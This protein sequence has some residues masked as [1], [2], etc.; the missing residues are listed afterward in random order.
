MRLCSCGAPRL[1]TESFLM[2]W[3]TNNI[4]LKL[5]LE[6]K[7]RHKSKIQENETQ[8]TRMYLHDTLNPHLAFLHIP[9]VKLNSIPSGHYGEFHMYAYT[10]SNLN[11]QNYYSERNDLNFP[12]EI[13]QSF[14]VP[15]THS[16][17]GRKTNPFDPSF[18]FLR[19]LV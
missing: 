18:W 5:G 14:C 19:V 8:S 4:L 9:V 1:S 7:T 6:K 3:L 11:M 12:F 13:L 16:Y 10:G 2:G 15:S 17:S